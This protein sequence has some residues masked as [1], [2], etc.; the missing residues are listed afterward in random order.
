[1]TRSFHGVWADLHDPTRPVNGVMT[2]LTAQQADAPG[3]ARVLMLA[4]GA[5]LVGEL[6]LATRRRYGGPV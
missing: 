4:V 3:V 1:M 6:V 2:A 5:V